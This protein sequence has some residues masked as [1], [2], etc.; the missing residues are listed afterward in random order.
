MNVPK[1]LKYTKS[2][3]WIEFTG[4]KTAKVGITDYAQ[5]KLGDL[6]FVNIPAV[7]AI[8]KAGEP[9]TDVESVKSV[10][11]VFSPITGVISA[12]NEALTDKPE[13]INED[14]YGAWI[15]E[16]SDITEKGELIDAAEYEK[17]CEEEG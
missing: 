10:S 1:N 16:I 4:K 7:G 9:I 5:S 17:F 3:E 14:A 13:L 11:D 15:A 2:H 12:V 6:V 8:V